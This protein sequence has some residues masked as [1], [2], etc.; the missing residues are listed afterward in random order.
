MCSPSSSTACFR[1]SAL[2]RW[3]AF[4]PTT[5]GTAPSRASTRTRWPTRICGI[6]AADRGEVEKALLVDM[7]DHEADL[8]D[9]A[10]DR[11]QRLGLVAA[12]RRH[13]GADPVELWVGERRRLPPDRARRLLIAGGGGRGEQV[14]AVR[15]LESSGNPIPGLPV[16]YAARSAPV[17]L[18]PHS[19]RWLRVSPRHPGPMPAESVIEDA[20]RPKRRTRREGYRDLGRVPAR[21]GLARPTPECRPLSEGDWAPD[22]RSPSAPCAPR[23]VRRRA[24]EADQGR[25]LD[26]RGPRRWRGRGA[27]P[28]IRG[29]ALGADWCGEAGASTSAPRKLRRRQGLHAPLPHVTCRRRGRRARRDSGDHR[30]SDAS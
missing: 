20:M 24:P 5:P 21:F 28:S 15:G 18:A 23:R 30:R 12:D 22:R 7:G 10:D 8:V 6:P 26:G 9:V 1:C 19:P 16:R 3:I 13:R 25:V 27:Q 11:E 14:G 29:R 17:T 2:S 4:R